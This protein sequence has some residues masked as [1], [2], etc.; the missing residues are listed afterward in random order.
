ML[1][2]FKKHIDIKFPLLQQTKFLLACSGGLDSVVLAY[3]C[4]KCNLDFSIAHCNFNLRGEDSNKD[5]AFVKDLAKQLNKPFFVT[6]FDTKKYV[7]EKKTSTQIAARELRY[8]WFL[9]LLSIHKLSYIVTAHHA[10][11]AV[12]TFLINLS[13]GTGIDGLIGI[14]EHTETL[15]RPLLNFSREEINAY[16]SEENIQWREDIS[17]AETK[18]IRNKIR[19]KIMPVLK[20][21]HPSFL[22]N[23]KKT[24]HFLG[25]TAEISEQSIQKL[26]QELFNKEKEIVKI[27]IADLAVLSPQKGYIYGLFKSY[28]F[29]AWED[30]VSLLI[31]SSGKEVYS[32]THRL[33]KDRSHLLLQPIKIKQEKTYLIQ[34]SD[35]FLAKP[36]SLKISSVAAIE[37]K[38]KDIIYVSRETLKFPLIV[39]KWRKG[40]YFYPFGMRGKKRVAKFFKD[41]KLNAI[42]K[43]EQWLLCSGDDIIW[44]I[45]RRSDNRFKVTQKGQQVL[46]FTI[47]K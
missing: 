21:L 32:K 33:V 2:S 46:K 3:L 42:A 40:D 31:A 14:P 41:E 44:I 25:Q 15:A 43:E 28:G 26:K 9:E 37:E 13:R 8:A 23:F 47:D 17:N 38:S 12:E 27:S 11:D 10:D 7:A 30:I 24:Q 1:E 29:T 5:E 36:I 45:G 18:Y 20:E 19:H 39:R 22:D 16:A 6:H 4:A 34:E 35:T